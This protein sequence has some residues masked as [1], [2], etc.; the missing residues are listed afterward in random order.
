MSPANV[1]LREGL[2]ALLNTHVQVR[3]V[4]GAD[5]RDRGAQPGHERAP[6]PAQLGQSLDRIQL[7]HGNHNTSRFLDIIHCIFTAHGGGCGGRGPVPVQPGLVSAGLPCH[8]LHR[9]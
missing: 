9:V 1:Q 8:A 2:T 3:G 6:V 4:R 5:Q 7:R